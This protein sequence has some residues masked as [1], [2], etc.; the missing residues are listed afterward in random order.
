MCSGGRA[1]TREFFYW[2]L[3]EAQKPLQ[4]VSF[5]HWKAVKNGPQAA[6]ELY[7]LAADPGE[8][9]DLAAQKPE[10][11][12]KAVALMKSAHAEDPNWPLTGLAER[13]KADRQGAAG[14]AASPA[15]NPSGTPTPSKGSL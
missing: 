1:P 3:H 15:R 12:A 6:L 10:L 9:Q 7:D 13:R 8:K 2:E 14:K 4:A 11:V 5:G